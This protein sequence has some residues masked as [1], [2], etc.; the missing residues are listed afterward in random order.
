ML[1]NKPLNVMICR[2]CYNTEPPEALTLVRCSLLDSRLHDLVEAEVTLCPGVRP[3]PTGRASARDTESV[4]AQGCPGPGSS[5]HHW[6]L[7]PWHTSVP[8]EPCGEVGDE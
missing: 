1:L 2:G 4:R 8:G 6:G 5:C 7:H 3:T